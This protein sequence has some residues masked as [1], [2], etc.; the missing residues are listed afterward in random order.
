MTAVVDSGVLVAAAD[1]RDRL[2]AAAAAVLRSLR[3][4]LM[5]PEPVTAEA[6]Y[7]IG[8]RAGREA[9]L[10]FIEDLGRGLIEVACLSPSELAEVAAVDR[11]YPALDLGLADAAI[12]VIAHRYGTRRLVTF[13]ERCF[14]SVVPLQGGSFTLLPADA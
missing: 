9:R 11:R 10:R 14:R 6:D 8:R 13:D 5:I 1:R 12:V 3:G 4:E 7:L 2:H